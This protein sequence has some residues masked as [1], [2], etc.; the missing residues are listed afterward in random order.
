MTA[1][2]TSFCLLGLFL[3]LYI[4]P[5]QTRPLF[6]Q[7]ETR[8]AE[9]PREMVTSGDWVVPRINGL[10]Y[11]EKPV[12]GYWL[13]AIS[14]TI[15]GQNNFAVRFPSALATG[16]T[17]LL[18]FFLCR[19]FQR[20]NDFLP[21]LAPLVYLTSLGIATTGTFAILDTPLTLFLTA[22]LVTFFL[23]TEEA[24][25]SSWEKRFLF[26][27]GVFAGCAF[28][29]KGFLAF[30]VPVL[31]VAPYLSL[32]KRWRDLLR[33]LWLP[34]AGAILVSLPWAILIHLREPNFWHYF[35]WNEHVRRFLAD[36]AQHAQPFWFFS[37]VLP[38]MFMPWICL[39]PA[40]VYGAYR[41]P[42]PDGPQRR[43][44][45]YSLCW[46]LFPFLFFSASSGKLITYILPCFP[47]LS[48]LF[49]QGFTW[50]VA[51]KTTEKKHLQ[52][53]IMA[54]LFLVS[55]GLPTLAGLHLF[56]PDY[57]Q[58]FQRSWKWLLLSSG[59]AAMLL[60]LLIAF[61][62]NRVQQKITFFALAFTVLLFT[63]H[64]T[65]PA[66]TLN[67]KAP[68]PL[69]RRHA[70]SITPDTIVLSGEEMA[71]A[72]C[73]YL[74]RN[75]IY[76]VELAGELQYG[77]DYKDSSHRKLSPKQAGAFI[78][79]H[80]GK[81]VLIAGH[82]EYSRWQPFLPLPYAVDSSGSKGYLLIRY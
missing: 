31:A 32:Q 28:L 77:L 14:L 70:G 75:D 22:T 73:W 42:L 50:W 69:I 29:T 68:G 3:F 15:F 36:S 37:A 54:L 20:E 58:L 46:F 5:L 41:L 45:I 7:D 2:Y 65:I 35:F 6:I 47:P 74:K 26:A 67:M 10:R 25:G 51:E 1:K 53:G 78:R 57:L 17:A 38:A 16:L 4:V 82:D 27:A 39:L 76:L 71:R 64:F 79:R 81:T 24:P 49:T 11:F 19:R 63:A 23:A 48:I 60:L 9:V 59:M 61:R 56:G 72:V 18:L 44:I 80:R 8:Y 43:L 21:F 62:S 66:L 52:W 30:A 34:L 55:L 12:M 40:A 33:M 13:T